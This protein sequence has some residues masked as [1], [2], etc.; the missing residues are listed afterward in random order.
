VQKK[1]SAKKKA[2]P[3]WVS[4]L[5]TRLVALSKTLSAPK[6][7]AELGTSSGKYVP[8]LTVHRW[9]KGDFAPQNDTKR[10]EL[11]LYLT[12]KGI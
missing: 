8:G 4:P 1:T 10:A 7:A 11:D 9:I 3:K 12:S 5:R 2:K 6:I